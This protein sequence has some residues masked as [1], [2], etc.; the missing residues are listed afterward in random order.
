MEL[1][2]LLMRM[3]MKNILRL[4]LTAASL[5]LFV[6]C[7]NKTTGNAEELIVPKA[8]VTTTSLKKGHIEEQIIIERQNRISEEK[9]SGCT[10]F[11]LHY[12][13]ECKIWR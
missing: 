1:L 11:G 9:R 4:L 10:H 5:S 8:A 13:S 2:E 12:C 6:S 7:G 3:K